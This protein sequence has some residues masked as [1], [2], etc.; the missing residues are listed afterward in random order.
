MNVFANEKSSEI[1]FRLRE[2]ISLFREKTPAIFESI[3]QEKM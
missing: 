3:L 1:I 2:L